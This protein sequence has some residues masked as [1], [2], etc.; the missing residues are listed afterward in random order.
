M[1]DISSVVR[2]TTTFREL[3]RELD[4]IYVL[5]RE[6][7]QKAM[8]LFDEKVSSLR[9]RVV[10]VVCSPQGLYVDHFKV[11]DAYKVQYLWI[12]G[13]YHLYASKKPFS[14]FHPMS[15]LRDPLKAE[16]MSYRCNVRDFPYAPGVDSYMELKA[17]KLTREDR[18]VLSEL[19]EAFKA[20]ESIHQ[21][22]SEVYDKLQDEQITD[23]SDLKAEHKRL[24]A[25]VKETGVIQ[26]TGTFE[27]DASFK[28]LFDPYIHPQDIKPVNI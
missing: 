3:N 10:T 15:S 20:R 25:K 18:L 24:V 26:V 27:F 16:A 28:S 12:T 1:T 7:N 9:G 5:S 6:R 13:A 11:H 21:R 2:N 14:L 22:K 8:R 23:K 19:L 17:D 4:G